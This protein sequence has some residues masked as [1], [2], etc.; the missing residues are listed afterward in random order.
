MFGPWTPLV[1][2][3]A[4]LLPLLWIKRRVTE[5]L[6]VLSIRWLGDR[7][8]ALVVY[9]VVLLP[10]VVVHE[11][12]HWLTA[13]LLGVK[14]R[15]FHL[16]PVR[17]GKRLTLGS[18]QVANVD[19]VRISLIGLAP[20]VVGSALILLIGYR[21]LGIGALGELF[22]A[23]GV[24]GLLA[25]LDRL[26]HVPDFWLW[27]YLIFAISN[28]MLPSEAD[29][30]PLRPVLLFLGIVAGG[31]LLLH[32]APTLSPAT[33]ERANAVAGYLA[34]AFGL[35]LAVDLLFGGVIAALLWLT[36]RQQAF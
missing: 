28:A 4:T 30:A 23:G 26:W 31:L 36:D 8:V 17:R 9:F 19:P 34:S 33:V 25:G 29:L 32:G 11:A 35:T 13:K 2:L 21:V 27:L 15:R 1:A 5:N 22:A 10:G 14:V 24:E 6:A 18:V 3:A 7:D 12:S 16:G 20:L